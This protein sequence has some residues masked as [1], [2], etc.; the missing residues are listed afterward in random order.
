MNVV[1]RV[2]EIM[3][4]RIVAVIE[5]QFGF[6]SE[7]GTINAVFILRRLLDDYHAKG[8]KTYM[9]FVDL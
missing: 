4:R 9:C 6:M 5:M 1:E 8:E 7:R 2:L 3:L